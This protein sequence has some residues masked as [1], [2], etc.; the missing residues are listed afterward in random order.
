[1]MRSFL[2]SF[3]VLAAVGCLAGCAVSPEEG[4]AGAAVTVPPAARPVQGLPVQNLS[5]MKTLARSETELVLYPDPE[6]GEDT[7]RAYSLKSVQDWAGQPLKD[8]GI[9][10]DILRENDR[11]MQ[12]RLQAESMTEAQSALLLLPAAG[13]AVQ[14]DVPV[15][16]FPLPSVSAPEVMRCGDQLVSLAVG[17]EGARLKVGSRT[18]DL[19][20]K[21]AASGVRYTLPT[22]ETTGFWSHGS[23]ETLTLRGR[24]YPDCMP[25]IQADRAVSASGPG[26]TLSLTGQAM[27]LIADGR[28]PLVVPTPAPARHNH[29]VHYGYV[30]PEE[31]PSRRMSVSVQDATCTDPKL[32][33]PRPLAVTVS[34]ERQIYNGCAGDPVDLLLG[35]DWIISSLNGKPV[36]ERAGLALGFGDRGRL[37]G[38]TGCNTLTGTY[39]VT[40]DS[41]KTGRA[42]TTLRACLPAAAAVESDFL[43]ALGR[44]QFFTLMPDGS[45]Q[46]QSRDGVLMTARR[47]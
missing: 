10:A 18:Y 39:S 17:K 33:Q 38:N 9:P 37:T 1:M 45:L 15:R 25:V 12:I 3:V 36:P 24:N 11:Y 27:H 31:K 21:P 19:Q 20:Q 6:R 23:G 34:L 29:L 30:P 41:L 43:A 42:A 14:K 47:H 8:L 32:R 35:P 7:E 28:E 4:K 40:P 46:L 5:V 44:L 13:L 2:S 26:W 16:L 22:D